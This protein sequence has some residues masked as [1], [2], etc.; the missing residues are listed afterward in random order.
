[1]SRGDH[2]D[3]AP[4]KA[5]PAGAGLRFLLLG[6]VAFLGLCAVG[7]LAAMLMAAA[8]GKA[9]TTAAQR[10]NTGINLSHIGLALHNYHAVHG[11]LPPP[12]TTTPEGKPGLSW[13]VLILPHLEQ[14]NLY[15]QF[16]LDEP[17]DSPN[18]RPLS[19][20]VVKAYCHPDDPLSSLT[21]FRVFV[22]GGAAFEPG[23]KTLLLPARNPDELDFADGTSTTFLVVEAADA[24]PWAKPEELDYNPAAPLPKLGHPAHGGDFHALFANGRVRTI[25]RTTAEATLRALITCRGGEPVPD[26]F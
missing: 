16:K 20:A 17:W 24:V 26:D 19:D 21:R 15:K 8:Q 13:R 1:M 11:R 4:T 5:Q 14:D 25:E 22:G 23:K 18:N 9:P 12:W 3:S 2:E 6:A 7:I 10:L